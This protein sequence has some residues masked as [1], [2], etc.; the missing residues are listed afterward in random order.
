MRRHS[1]CY[2]YELDT[3][4]AV[5]VAAYLDVEHYM[6]LHNK[7]SPDYK[8]HHVEK[9]KIENSQNWKFGW[10]RVGQTYTNEY[11]PPARFRNYDVRSSNK[12]IP[13]IHTLINVVTDLRY[14]PTKDGRRTKSILNVD[15]DIPFWLWPTRKYIENKIKTI[16]WEKDLEDMDMIKRREALFGFGNYQSYLA[17]H[18]F[19]IHKD[20]FVEHF[21][22]SGS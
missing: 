18:Q 16:K 9:H 4:V 22:P 8:V 3:T 13:N 14:E 1:F 6:F 19:M 15:L 5:A 7:Y 2:E 10:F 21:G 20:S 11:F 12:L 17:A